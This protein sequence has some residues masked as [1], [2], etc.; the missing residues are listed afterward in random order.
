VSRDFM[1]ILEDH[2]KRRE[3]GKDR[4]RDEERKETRREKMMEM[5]TEREGK[6]Q[7]I[8]IPDAVYAPVPVLPPSTRMAVSSPSDDGTSERCERSEEIPADGATLFE[9][10]CER[11]ERSELIPTDQTQGSALRSLLLA[12]TRQVGAE[13]MSSNRTGQRHLLTTD[14]LDALEF[15]PNLIDPIVQPGGYT[16]LCGP[17]SGG[18]SQLSVG[19][20]LSV[21]MGMSWAGC[22]TRQ[23]SVLYLDDHNDGL[24]LRRRVEAWCVGHGVSPDD[25]RVAQQIAIHALPS[26]PRQ[27]V[28]ALQQVWA[29]VNPKL[30]I[31]DLTT[32]RGSGDHGALRGLVQTYCMK[33]GCAAVVVING[34]WSIADLW[35]GARFLLLRSPMNPRQSQNHIDLVVR[36]QGGYPFYYGPEFEV[37]AAAGDA[38]LRVVQGLTVARH[39]T[40]FAAA[41]SPTMTEASGT[42]RQ[43]L[44][45]AEDDDIPYDTRPIVEVRY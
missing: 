14:Q 1:R 42:G 36:A 5:R 9:S 3:H 32:I 33:T 37:V 19:I 43:G 39:T 21:A 7:G 6:D 24:V 20:A 8:A 28:E 35:P 13:S 26:S 30:A 31:L 45:P 10:E 34:L 2:L 27:M 4:E 17:E 38:Y 23:A 29:E 16:V 11:S 18:N 25:S 40:T 22:E 44:S 15:P 12:A 41:P